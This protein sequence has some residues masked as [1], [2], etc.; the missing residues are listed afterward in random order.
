M[1]VSKASIR[2]DGLRADESLCDRMFM[3]GYAVTVLGRSPVP[4]FRFLK[5]VE[6]FR[7]PAAALARFDPE[8]P[9]VFVLACDVYRFDAQFIAVARRHIGRYDAAVPVVEGARQP[10]CALYRSE[11]FASLRQAVERGELRLLRWV[12]GLK[13]REITAA[14]L[15]SAGLD[16]LCVRGANDPGEL[17]TLLGGNLDRA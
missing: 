6:D 8:T 9:Y 3:A 14:E 10:L 5:D 17:Q 15:V 2:V 11:C 12:D 7:G 13:V 16:P 4:G 1:G